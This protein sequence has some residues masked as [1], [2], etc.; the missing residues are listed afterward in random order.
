MTDEE[1][2]PQDMEIDEEIVGEEGLK[3]KLASLKQDLA[4]VKKERQEYLDGWQ[5]AK[6]DSV[7]SRKESIQQTDRILQRAEDAYVEELLPVL[8]S[9]DMAM[10]SPTWESVDAEWRTGADGLQLLMITYQHQLGA[11]AGD[12]LDER[13]KHC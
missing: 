7:N 10:K 1:N 12:A 4:A 2:I 9:F 13:R 5:R 6:A 8:D 3:A 11:S